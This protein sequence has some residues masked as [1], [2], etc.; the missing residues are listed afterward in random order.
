MALF[1]IASYDGRRSFVIFSDSRSSLQSLRVLYPRNPL[2]TEI[3]RFLWF[4]HSRYR[5]VSFCWVP[6]HVG[7]PGNEHADR[8]AKLAASQ[9][10]D[11]SA[12]L[13]ESLREGHLPY[14]DFLSSVRSGFL[15][16]W[17]DQWSNDTRG[18][19]LR[20]VKPVLGEWPSPRGLSRSQSVTLTRLRIGHT[21]L[22]HEYR[23]S[24]DLRPVCSLC[25]DRPF[26]S[27]Q[28]VLSECTGTAELRRRYFP[29]SFFTS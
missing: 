28:H 5:S 6:S 8:E 17:Q 27:V 15:D 22:T 25:A 23:M 20:S 3:Q 12:F 26:L 11:G 21:R 2:I 18:A 14:R 29:I 16:S 24:G 10:R 7:I 4:L 9:F 19:K 1:H 13:P